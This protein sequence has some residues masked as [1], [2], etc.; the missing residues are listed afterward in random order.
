MPSPSFGRSGSPADF[1]TR[2]GGNSMW[3]GLDRFRHHGAQRLIVAH[4]AA[5]DEERR[6]AG[7]AGGDA[8]ADVPLHLLAR[9]G[10]VA[11]GVELRAV[12]AERGRPPAVVGALQ[13][14]LMLEEEV[15]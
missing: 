1:L 14:A 3:R 4:G 6:R 12:E 13:V 15:V 8:V 5:V 11:A 2:G 7:D 9:L 10:R